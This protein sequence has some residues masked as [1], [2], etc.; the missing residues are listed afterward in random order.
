MKNNIVKKYI[1]LFAFIIIISGATYIM[2]LKS[3]PLK[4]ISALKSI[5]DSNYTYSINMVDNTF[6]KK[7]INKYGNT[8]VVFWSS[9]C[10]HCEN[11]AEALNNFIISNKESQ[12]IIV[13]SHDKDYSQLENYLRE[14][15]YNWNIILDSE[16]TIREHIDPGKTGIPASYL[17]DKNGNIINYYK[18]EM[19]LNNFNRFVNLE[20]LETE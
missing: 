6:L 8:L 12:N 14:H 16:K 9:L 19:T 3:K 15:N 4:E 17:L 5:K 13:V 1:F 10:S 11:E 18:G 2:F 20:S 7:Y